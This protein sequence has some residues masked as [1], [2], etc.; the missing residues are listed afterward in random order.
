[1]RSRCSAFLFL[2]GLLS[3][4]RVAPGLDPVAVKSPDG[5]VEFQLTD[6]DGGRLG[7]QVLFRGKP[8][9]E[10]SPLG[11]VVDG[12][13]LGDGV[14]TSGSQR[15]QTDETYPWHGGHST[16]VDKSNGARIAVTHR[17]SGAAYTLDVRAYD[18]GVAFRFVVPGEGSRVP[19]EATV[20][21]LPAQGRVW[22]HDAEDHYEGRYIGRS[23]RSVPLGAWAA[24]PLTVRLP[25]DNGY[26]AITEGGLRGYSG[27]ML[28][29]DGE[30]GFHA[31]LGHAVP[32]SW[33]FRLRFEQDVER[34]SHPASINGTITTPWR[35]VMIGADLN[36]LV[37]SDIVHNVAEP[38]DTKLFPQGFAADWMQPGRAVWNYL[39]G[40]SGTLEGM[41]EFS[42]LAGEL[43]FEYSVLEGFWARWPESDLK[44]LVDYSRERGVRILIWK[45]SSELS[46]PKAAE[47]FFDM[48]RRTGAAGA[49]IDFFDHEHKDI[50]DLYERL[51]RSAAEHHL[52]LDFHGANKPTGLERTYPNLL[53]QEA[54]RGL[55]T[56]PP[57]AQHNATLP[58]TRMLA[59]LADYTPMHFGRKLGDTTWPHQIATAV[60]LWAPLLVYAAHPANILTNP[61]VDVIKDI[62]SVWDETVVLPVSEIGEVAAFARRKGDTWYLAV[63]NGPNERTIQVDLSFLD[64]AERGRA[65]TYYAAL[66]GDATEAA[67]VDIRHKTMSSDDSLF[68]KMRSG[69]GFIGRF[70]RSFP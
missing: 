4:P 3:M 8:V 35:V 42:R 60:I 29:G 23:V 58:F 1:M 56:G 34:M 49:K 30:S 66:V 45:R 22:F 70:S 52:I 33:P 25:D 19:T 2:L 27:M 57:Y 46:D 24:P 5:R 54:I 7:Y 21:R 53:G 64:S 11:I 62:P 47:D 18:T 26:A 16:A 9:I 43:G 31:R 20:F 50:I 15:Y 59:G 69:G 44:D 14:E 61:A 48:C 10:A 63:V 39:D 32:A 55:E 13:S 41:K 36:E 51:L 6:L 37:N 12:V 65:P 68:I 38:P 67:A 17:D 40:G 28:Q